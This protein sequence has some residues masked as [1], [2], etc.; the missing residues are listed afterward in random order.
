ME[1]RRLAGYSL[2]GI[3]INNFTLSILL[4]LVNITKKMLS[5]AD[6]WLTEHGTACENGLDADIGLRVKRWF[7]EELLSIDPASNSLDALRDRVQEDIADM[8]WQELGE[9]CES[10]KSL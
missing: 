3:S 7:F 10:I 4:E 2:L 6:R 9:A 5:Y 8:V 1:I